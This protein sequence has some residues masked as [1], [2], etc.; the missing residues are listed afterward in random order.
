MNF[1]EVENNTNSNIDIIYS[2]SSSSN[3]K[4]LTLILSS[5][6]SLTLNA[7]NHNKFGIGFSS[8]RFGV[9]HEDVHIGTI[10][11]PRFFQPPHSND[12]VVQT[13]VLLEDVN[14]TKILGNVTSS[15]SGDHDLGIKILGDAKAH[16]WLLR[17]NFLDIKV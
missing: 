17:I 4:T 7:E 16:I 15:Q 3:N 11:I 10:R 9:Y 12:V 13:R 14:V 8:M 5:V 2:N 1:Y 6:L